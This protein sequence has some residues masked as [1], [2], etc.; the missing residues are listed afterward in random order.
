MRTLFFTG[1]GDKG[2]SEVG[3]NGF[4]KG[5]PAFELLGGLDEL[6]SFLGFARAEA[7]KNPPAGGAFSVG[8][9]LKR[10]QELL[11]IAQAETAARAFRH[12]S[13]EF[14][15]IMPGHVAE[16]E[17][18]ITEVDRAVP[19]LTAFVIPGENELSARLDLAR[20]AARRAERE[21]VRNEKALTL[22]P[23][24]LRFLNRLSS[25]LFALAR[26]ASHEKE[27]K[28]DSPGYK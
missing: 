15:K 19:P 22:S 16:L 17:E 2:K 24:F 13:A 8:S 9:T 12:R 21:A 25:A 23:D 27:V 18:V 7:K 1:R 5:D 11:F 6:N 28:E 14:Q 10:L 4:S 26:Y 3:G 20:T